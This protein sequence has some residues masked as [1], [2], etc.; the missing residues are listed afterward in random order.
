[1][2]EGVTIEVEGTDGAIERF[3][4]TLL[5]APPPQA[6]IRTVTRCRVAPQGE[7]RFHIAQSV[8]DGVLQ[9]SLPPDLATC[10]DCVRELRDRADRRF[11]YPFINCTNCGPRYTIVQALPYDR[12]RTGMAGFTMCAE[13]SREYHDPG[14]RRFDAQPNACARCGPHLQLIDAHAAPLPGDAIEQTA[15]LLHE[16]AIVAIKGLGGFHLACDGR[17]DAVV[18]RLRTRKRRP[19]RALAVMCADIPQVERHVICTPHHRTQLQSPAAPIVICER[20]AHS[21][22]SHHLSPDTSDLGVLLPYTPVHHLL[23]QAFGHPLVMTSANMHNE[24][25]VTDREG[26]HTL[27]GPVADAALVHDRPIVHRCDDSVLTLVN[28]EPLFFRRSRGFVPE[29]LDLPADGPP[30]LACGAQQKTLVCLCTGRC[31]YLSPHIGDLDSFGVYAYYRELIEEMQRLFAVTV[32]VLAHDMHP[33]YAST[34]YAHYRAG[35]HVQSSHA[36]WSKE[37]ANAH[38]AAHNAH[39]ASGASGVCPEGGHRIEPAAARAGTGR[40][41][42]GGDRLTIS[43]PRLSAQTGGVRT[44][45][46][47]HHHAHIAG[48]MAEHGLD[49]PVIGV[50]LDGTGYGDD[51]TIWGGE[52]LITHYTHYLRAGHFRACPMPGGDAAVKQPARMALAYAVCDSGLDID[53]LPAPLVDH[54]GAQQARTLVA[55]AQKGINAP[56]TSSCGRLFDAVAALC[57]VCM[58]ADYDGQ[59]PIRLQQRCAQDVHGHYPYTCASRQDGRVVLVFSDTIRRIVAEVHRGMAPGVIAARFHNTVVDAVVAVCR[60]I[61]TQHELHRVALS[62][63]VF[64]NTRILD[65]VRVRLQQEG[66]DVFAHRLQPP[67]DACIAFGQAVVA[68]ARMCRP[69]SSPYPHR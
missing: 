59:A 5:Q 2:P 54:L 11:R 43:V 18:A 37:E 28:E 63:G 20:R 10:N 3:V 44:C 29:P 40:K 9:A 64:Q 57:G 52:F 16:G 27:L 42:T 67:N 14:D 22:L 39:C 35:H 25:L 4:D 21:G 36:Q 12:E 56:L 48:C 58:E 31:A 23:C 66:F 45:A 53:E 24:P 60:T 33:D 69:E 15:R 49:G 34:R 50:A 46:V 47:Q 38:A 68:R 26:L 51:G 6:V 8:Q 41:H 13:C 32:Q 19:A 30:V 62:G 7:T 17:S 1:M 55:A 61:R 65:G